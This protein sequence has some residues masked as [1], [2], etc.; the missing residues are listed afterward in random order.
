MEMWLTAVRSHRI[1]VFKPAC[2]A[3]PWLNLGDAA[4]VLKVAS[5]TLRLAAEAGVI[6]AVHPL[7]DGPWIFS[8]A[9]LSS[10]AARTITDRARQNPRYLTGSHLDQQSLFP[11][12]VQMRGC[13]GVASDHDPGLCE[14][15]EV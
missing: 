1:P 6:E 3:E 14:G 10:S 5:K 4:R 9:D 12:G 7:P 11:S 2:E 8:R 13:N 15:I